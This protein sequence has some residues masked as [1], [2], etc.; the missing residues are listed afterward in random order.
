MNFHI[1]RALPVPIWLQLKGLIEYG[2]A[3]GEF[4]PGEPL[5]SVRELADRTAVAPMT[6]SHVYRELKRLGLLEARPG[7]GTFVA[8][9]SRASIAARPAAVQFWAALD[10]AI[11]AGLDLGI[12]PEDLPALVN[13][14]LASRRGPGRAK[15]VAMIGLFP[16]VTESYARQIADHLGGTAS[17]EPLTIAAI[18]RDPVMRARARSADLALTFINRQR[19]VAALLPGVKVISIS[20][21]PSEE[22][23]R[24]LASMS[25][26][27]RVGVVSRFPEFLPIMKAGVERFAP[28]V[29]RVAGASL[30]T[31]Q[32][33]DGLGAS[34]VIVY[35]SGAE[36][37]LRQFPSV[38]AI[39]YRHIPDPAEIKR[40][41][42]PLLRTEDGPLQQK[43]AS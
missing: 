33:P 25:P 29:S 31:A 27:A 4:G 42:L 21:I 22:T 2:I 8:D 12:R 36:V 9:T 19:A 14:R 43:A 35:A 34:D 28:H 23:R 40:V 11:D 13:A 1:D 32:L 7:A 38:P 41:L 16:E 3:C 26:L 17:V 24:A 37:V 5:P 6:V 39:E 20:F 15:T 10:T 30:D 18:E